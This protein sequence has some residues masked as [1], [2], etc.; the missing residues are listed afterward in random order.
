MDEHAEMFPRFGVGIAAVVAATWPALPLPA[1]VVNAS[2]PPLPAARARESYAQYL[3][4]QRPYDGLRAEAVRAG[5]FD[6]SNNRASFET[7]ERAG[8]PPAGSAAA[9]AEAPPRA[10]DAHH[11]HRIV[12]LEQLGA[13]A[14]SKDVRGAQLLW[15]ELW[16][17]LLA[18]EVSKGVSHKDYLP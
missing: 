3:R 10:R 4:R 6:L 7:A 11:A 16:T 18:D 8:A 1:G 9:A 17:F 13:L 12:C 5:A 2:A 15:R 14:R